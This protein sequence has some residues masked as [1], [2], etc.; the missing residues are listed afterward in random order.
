MAAH[1]GCTQPGRGALGACLPLHGPRQ[2]SLKKWLIVP[3]LAWHREDPSCA[4]SKRPGAR[5][6]GRYLRGGLPAGPGHCAL[7]L[8]H[9]GS[10]QQLLRQQRRLW[11]RR[12]PASHGPAP[13]PPPPHPARPPG[14]ASGRA[15]PHAPHLRPPAIMSLG[16]VQQ[17]L[18]LGLLVGAPGDLVGTRGIHGQKLLPGGR[19]GEGGAGAGPEAGLK[20]RLC[21]LTRPA[22][23]WQGRTP[24]Q[25]QEER[26]SSTAQA[27]RTLG[28]PTEGNWWVETEGEGWG[29]GIERQ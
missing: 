6:A 1:V 22:G 19:C 9:V 7:H 28:V 21:T 10:Q 27:H 20:S 4:V 12:R 8:L 5:R 15:G 17:V 25:Q 23:C 11:P 18:L 13:A 29:Q 16:L 14:R 3:W 24:G 26:W 2:K